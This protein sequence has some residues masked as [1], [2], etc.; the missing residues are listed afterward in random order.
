M[1]SVRTGGVAGD[2]QHDVGQRLLI[3][4]GL[5]GAIEARRILAVETISIVRVICLVVVTEEIRFLMSRRLAMGLSSPLI[6]KHPN[7]ASFAM[8]SFLKSPMTRKSSASSVIID[9]RGPNL[10]KQRRK[11]IVHV[12]DER[13]TER[14]DVGD[15]Q[16]IQEA[17]VAGEQRNDLLANL[18]RLVAR[19]LGARSC[20]RRG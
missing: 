12:L 8:N 7:G 16:V 15:L 14:Q 5:L 6:Q 3:G 2:R 9:L 18:K 4:L 1:G 11:A 13:V 19:L 20:E 10:V 17:L